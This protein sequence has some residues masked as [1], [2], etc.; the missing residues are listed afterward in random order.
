VP[1]ASAYTQ[2]RRK[3]KGELFLYLNDLIRDSFYQLSQEDGQDNR[4]KG[5]R[6]IAVDATYLNVPDTPETRS[7]YSI[8]GNQYEGTERVQAMGSVAYDLLNEMG[9]SAVIDKKRAEKEFL[10]DTHIDKTQEGDILVMDRLN[11]DYGVMAYIMKKRREFVIR[12][13]RGS[14]VEVRRFWDSGKSQEVVELGVTQKQKEFVRKKG[15]AKRIR[16]RLVRV[17]LDNREVEV[18]GTSLLD[19][20][21]W[22]KEDLKWIYGK[23]WAVETY[24]DRI[25][26]V[27]EV[28]RFSG[29]S[30]LSIEQDFYG[31]IFL[32]T[33]QGVLSREAQEE[34]KEESEGKGTKNMQQVNQSVGYSAVLDYIVELFMNDQKSVEQT[35]D[36]LHHLFKTN[37]TL[38]REGRKFER[39]KATPS[40]KL[41][42]YRYDKRIIA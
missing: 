37:P 31:V 40:Q 20:E 12:F 35:L 7:C 1:T 21:G 14:F 38:R 16:V 23:R 22:T 36:E 28:E 18:L 41:W 5:R 24:F 17:E 11:A 3:L 34:L 27:F 42:F 10:F 13:P 9:I 25:K 32:S 15:L 4:W 30:V 2:A 33:L 6:V 39:N 29:Q 19:K 26:N 8:Q